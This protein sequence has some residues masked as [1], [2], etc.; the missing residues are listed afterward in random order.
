MSGV[1]FRPLPLVTIRVQIQKNLDS[2]IP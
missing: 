1:G 2:E